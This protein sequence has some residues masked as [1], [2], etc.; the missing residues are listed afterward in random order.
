M[1]IRRW[2]A[3]VSGPP[4]SGSCSRDTS[5]AAEFPPVET[6]GPGL[7]MTP[8]S[9]EFSGLKSGKRARMHT[10]LEI[11]ADLYDEEFLLPA[12]VSLGTL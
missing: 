7:G 9:S 8:V 4:L 1:G 11:T 5:K 6:H 10:A 3:T 12:V 2:S